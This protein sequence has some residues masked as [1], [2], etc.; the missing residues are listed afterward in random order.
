MQRK[1]K[2]VLPSAAAAL[3]DKHMASDAS[4]RFRKLKEIAKA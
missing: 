1:G 2:L 3:P 4:K